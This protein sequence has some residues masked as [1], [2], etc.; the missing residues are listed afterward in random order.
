[1]NQHLETAL[2]E[3]RATVTSEAPDLAAWQPRYQEAFAQADSAARW[4]L[5][6]S[7]LESLA[8][9][10]SEP[11]P[12]DPSQSAYESLVERCNAALSALR[13]PTNARPAMARMATLVMD[14]L[15]DLQSKYGNGEPLPT[16]AQ[17]AA[18]QRLAVVVHECAAFAGAMGLM[19][20]P[21]A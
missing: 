1:L 7:T 17:T 2:R 5:G 9:S 11:T 16:A 3:Y 21:A 10:S 12:F 4:A 8:P 6:A 18:D 14:A 19:W 13:A 15:V 20:T